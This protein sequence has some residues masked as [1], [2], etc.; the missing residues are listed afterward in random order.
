MNKRR[1]SR[2]EMIAWVGGFSSFCSPHI[3]S[4]P[5][6]ARQYLSE[7]MGRR[8]GGRAITSPPLF[9]PST[10]LETLILE[11]F[12]LSSQFKRFIKSRIITMRELD[13]S[14]QTVMFKGYFISTYLHAAELSVT[15]RACEG[16]TRAAPSLFLWGHL[17]ARGRRA[18]QSDAGLLLAVFP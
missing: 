1:T 6:E 9:P 5:M 17:P 3:Q 16:R 13:Q 8:G 18:K 7:K 12:Q 4:R 2:N 11:I 14:S 15:W 10:A